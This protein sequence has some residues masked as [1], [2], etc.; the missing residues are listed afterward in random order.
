[1]PLSDLL[2]KKNDELIKKKGTPH[3][4]ISSNRKL[5]FP[6][7][8]SA[9]KCIENKKILAINFIKSKKSND[10]TL[11]SLADKLHISFCI[12]TLSPTPHLLMKVQISY[13][14]RISRKTQPS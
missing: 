3:L 5:A 13:P 2:N 14:K 1:L 6:K 10:V 12:P 4:A 8:F 7:S 9:L 11:Y